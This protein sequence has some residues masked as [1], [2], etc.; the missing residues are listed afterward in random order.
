MKVQGKGQL[1]H[2]FWGEYSA[3]IV[4]SFKDT[5]SSRDALKV[6]GEPWKIHDKNSR[7]LFCICTNDQLGQ[8]T[9]QLVSFGAEEKKIASLA[10]SID[11]GEPFEI[12]V[13]IIPKEQESLF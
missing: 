2:R 3:V 12:E 10:K 13:P 8:V 1:H 4:L 11:F 5:C 6:L 7:A 9:A